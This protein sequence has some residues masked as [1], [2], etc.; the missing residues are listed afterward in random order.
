[1]TV[2]TGVARRSSWLGLWPS[3]RGILW[4]MLVVLVV[5]LLVTLVW[6]AGRYEASQVQTRLERDAT[7]ATSDIR[8]A[9]TRN[10][11][12]LQALQGSPAQPNT[13]V[14]E[15]TAV[16][17]EH[18]EMVRIEWRDTQLNVVM[19]IDSPYQ[20]PLFS[21]MARST[22]Q[23]DVQI[24]CG[25]ASRLSGPAYSTSHFL[26]QDDGLG[27]ELIEM[28]MPLSTAGQSTGYL[29]A[30]YS[31]QSMLV[32]L[33]GKQITRGQEVSF[34]EADG[35]RLAIHGTSRRGSNVFSAQQLLDLPGNTLV[36][37]M[38]SWRAAPDLF[39]NV[40]TALVTLMSVAL[41]CVL[42]LLGKDISRRLRAEREL[43][44]AL[45][46]RKAMEDSLVTGM[47]AR[48]LQG[49]ITYVNPALCQ[50]TGYSAAELVGI[51]SPMPYWP[52]EL[53]DEYQQR[54]AVRLSGH[55]PSREGYESVFLRKDGTR[56]PVL[57]IE[58]PL[59]N[60]LGMQT[61]WMSAIL[62]MTDQRRMEELSRASQ[63]R[64]QASARLATVGEMASLL[65][66]ELN[67][68]LAAISSYASGSLNML[69]E[70]AAFSPQDV[71]HAMRRIGEQAE[72]AGKVI[73][74]VHDFVRR[75]DQ[76]H[77]VVRPTALLD[78][79]MPLVSLQARKLG[80]RVQVHCA[81]DLASVQCD[82]TMVEQVLLNLARNAMQAMEAVP[83]HERVLELTAHTTTRLS[84]QA[85]IPRAGHWIEFT[86]SDCG[87]GIDATTAERL[88]TPFFTTKLEGM[89]LGLSLCRTVV[90]QHGGALAFEPRKPSGTIFKFTLPTPKS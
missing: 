51:T 21:R 59:I 45:A 85:D 27:L 10:V 86:V 20:K 62:D 68:P 70:H 35:T 25:L 89:G 83:L 36:L 30:T 31:L 18:R 74:S 56:F 40:L 79:I 88:F 81:P 42:V 28:C 57:I 48:D 3:R 50:M 34:T 44:E 84:A 77:E 14:Q 38:D 43:A 65:S 90:E 71:E 82:R 2:V 9:L 52:P 76:A 41:V 69:Q 16:L 29:V 55:L 60:A 13:W 4:A 66:H 32:E 17:R 80:V 37:R 78:A 7:E 87:T 1:M 6:L 58:A 23:S 19:A 72:R 54:Q 5:A 67:Q 63:E 75:R 46:F 39:P 33:I 64:L 53:A 49:R 15:A 8:I 12:N 22:T 26:P 61:G 24:A 11:Q 47:R 73:K